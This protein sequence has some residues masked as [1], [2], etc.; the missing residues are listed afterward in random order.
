MLDS[1]ARLIARS[2][3]WT[4]RSAELD[5]IRSW[6][7]GSAYASALGV[8]CSE[9]TEQSVKLRLPYAE[10]NSNPGTHAGSNVRWAQ[11]M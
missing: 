9:L 8:E 4:E 11:K 2:K 7:E 1:R 3:E 5:W 10:V 6:V